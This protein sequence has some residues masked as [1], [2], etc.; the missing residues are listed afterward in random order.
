MKLIKMLYGLT[1][2]LGCFVLAS[3]V[4]EEEGPCLPDGQTKVLF[5]LKLQDNAQTRAEA[6]R[7]NWGEG[8]LNNFERGV[9]KDNYIDLSGV[10]LL[11]F[12]SGNNY[13]GSL[14]DMIYTSKANG[15]EYY[16]EKVY[17]F[18]GTAPNGLTENA[19]YKFVVLANTTIPE[20]PKVTNLNELYFAQNTNAI[21]MWGVTTA[22]LSLVAGARQDIGDIALLRAISKVT[23]KLS[24]EMINAGYKLQS[25]TVDEYNTEGYVL[26]TNAFTVAATTSLDQETCVRPKTSAATSP[27]SGTIENDSV[28]FYL[29]EYANSTLKNAT[30]SVVVK[31]PDGYPME[32]LGDA[33]ITFRN[34]TSGVA[35]EGSE[36][37]I[38]RNHHYIFIITG[39]EIDRNLY[40][41]PYVL[42]WDYDAKNSSEFTTKGS[43]VLTVLDR[44]SDGTKFQYKLCD[45]NGVGKD[46]THSSDQ[47]FW[48]D[49]WAAIAYD[50]DFVSGGQN[51]PQFNTLL[52]LT[53]SFEHDSHMVLESSDVN[54]GFVYRKP[55]TNSSDPDSYSEVLDALTIDDTTAI[56]NEADGTYTVTYYVVPKSTSSEGDKTEVSLIMYSAGMATKMPYNSSILPGSSDNTGAYFYRVTSNTWSSIAYYTQNI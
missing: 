20:T 38:V 29:P 49:A 25:V 55:K 5:T 18:V 41:V 11:I 43:S 34:Y 26:P 50:P 16:E 21:P 44:T 24:P 12:D 56:Y 22:Q 23:V 3:C 17:E 40:I 39:A 14:K 54:F 31:D 15:T 33:G 4:N 42:P 36:Y 48:S 32:F 47:G 9:D 8:D 28:E 53:V 35:T 27:L 52:E 19:T 37:D 30:M 1:L 7:D 2:M 51:N 6:I 45:S 13:M 46:P 10:R